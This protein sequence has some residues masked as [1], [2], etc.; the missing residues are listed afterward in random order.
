MWGYHASLGGGGWGSFPHQLTLLTCTSIGRAARNSSGVSILHYR[1]E[2]RNGKN[3]Q[4]PGETRA[5]LLWVREQTFPS[6]ESIHISVQE[7]PGSNLA[8]DSDCCDGRSSYICSVCSHKFRESTLNYF[9]SHFFYI[10]FSE[11]IIR[12]R[13]VWV[14]GSVAE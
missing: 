13:R 2:G 4:P 12:H 5:I 14:T 8:Q 6:A 9:T 11:A 3:V 10:L 7:V 1:S